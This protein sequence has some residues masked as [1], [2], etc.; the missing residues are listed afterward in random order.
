MPQPA[1]MRVWAVALLLTV[2]ALGFVNLL[3]AYSQVPV[4]SPTWSA[5]APTPA[6]Q[7][8]GSCPESRPHTELAGEVVRWGA[9]HLQADAG[10]CCAACQALPACNVWVYCPGGQGCKASECWL[11]KQTLYELVPAGVMAASPTT[12]WVSGALPRYS[13]VPQAAALS[14]ELKVLEPATAVATP[15]PRRRECGSPAHDAYAS[16]DVACLERSATFAA[17]NHSQ[18]AREQL[19]VWVEQHASYDGLAV[20]WGVGNKHASAASCAEA[21]RKHE[22]DTS[23]R[24]RFGGQFGRL[25]CNAFVW[26]PLTQPRCFEPDAHTHSAGDCWLKFTEVPEQPEVN[27]RGEMDDGATLRDGRRYRQRHADAQSPVPWVS[28]VLLEPGQTPGNGTW[29]PRAQW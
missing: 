4:V 21:C 6:L 27:A 23:G 12:P 5:P 3:S 2:V 14:M 8:P 1:R 22:A 24:V 11:K 29:G 9:D 13:K 17:F 16:V 19:V 25:P 18:A 7:P 10:S 28:G 15:A 26:C 20:A